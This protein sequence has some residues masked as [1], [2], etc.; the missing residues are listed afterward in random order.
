MNKMPLTKFKQLF[1]LLGCS[2]C[3]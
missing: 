2:Y 3:P 1:N